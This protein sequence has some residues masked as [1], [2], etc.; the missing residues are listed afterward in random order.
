MD[1]SKKNDN[2]YMAYEKRYKQVYEHNY[3]WS[4][5]KPSPEVYDTILK[6]NI[7]KKHK[8]LEIGCGEGR[9]A[10]F[11]LNNGYNVLAVD[12]SKTVV[13]KC[14]ELSNYKYNDCFRQLDI[15]KDKL[16][17]KYN[18]IYSIAVIHMFV[19]QEHRSKFYKF[20]YNHLTN[21]G[22]ALIVSMGDGIKNFE[23]DT[24]KSFENVQR[25]VVNN[26]KKIDVAMTSCKMVDWETLEKE[27]NDN[28][29]MIIEKWI[30][31][32]VPEFNP[33]MCVI[34]HKKEE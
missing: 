21:N 24:N 29:L 23:S 31:N 14:K 7:S 10:I 5:I 9:D 32:E 34:V 30:S 6:Y 12:Y 8:I 33:A 4:T 25:T 27:I 28:R 22:F 13:E 20:V 18:F 26:E 17:G 11:L 15:I 3:L 16:N 1:K 2:Y 19:N